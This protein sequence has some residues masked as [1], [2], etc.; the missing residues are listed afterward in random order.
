MP[1]KII[2]C[3]IC[4]NDF[5]WTEGE[6]QFYLDRGLSFPKRCPDCRMSKN[7]VREENVRGDN[8]GT[9]VLS[10]TKQNL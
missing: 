9:G 8:Y 5:V 3:K 10:N 7:V 2:T 4:H 6:Q 1:N